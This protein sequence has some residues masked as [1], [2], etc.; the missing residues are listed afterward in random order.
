MIGKILTIF[1]FTLVTIFG[2]E[3]EF[4]EHGPYLVIGFY[5]IALIEYLSIYQILKNCGLI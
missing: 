3:M 5:F 1:Y 2:L 4:L